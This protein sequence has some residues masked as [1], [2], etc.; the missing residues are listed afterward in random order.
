MR[1]K[2]ICKREQGVQWVGRG[3]LMPAGPREA[4]LVEAHQA[5]EIIVRGSAFNPVEHGYRLGACARGH[6]FLKSR[7]PAGSELTGVLAGE[8]VQRYESIRYL[9][10][11]GRAGELNRAG[12]I[13]VR[14]KLADSQQDVLSRGGNARADEAAMAR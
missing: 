5:F 12:R 14:L 11:H 13:L 6:S 4:A 2:R 10:S 9:L 8:I 3:V 1:Q 7:A